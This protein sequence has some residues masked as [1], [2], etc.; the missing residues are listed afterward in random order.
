MGLS[1][2]LWETLPGATDERYKPKNI[3]KVWELSVLA[4][5]GP[6]DRAPQSPPFVAYWGGDNWM[7]RLNKL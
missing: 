3:A 1:S 4:A 2:K 7:M 6:G 5:E